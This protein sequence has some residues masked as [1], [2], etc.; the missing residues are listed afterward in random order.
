MLNSAIWRKRRALK[1]E[2]HLTK[3][4]KYAEAGK[5]PKPNAEKHFNW[6]SIAKDQ[7]PKKVLTDFFQEL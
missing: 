2:K 5:A 7:E 3:I 1:R 4:A 6:T